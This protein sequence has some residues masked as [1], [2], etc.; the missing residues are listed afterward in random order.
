MIRSDESWLG[1]KDIWTT[2]V[3]SFQPG[4][5]GPGG[6]KDD[7]VLKVGGWGDWYFTLIW[8]GMPSTGHKPQ[9]AAIALYSKD[10]EDASVPLAVD[11]IIH[12]WDFPKGG[13]LWWKDRPG[14]R[15]ITT[16]P[17]PAPKREQWYII[18][19]TLIVKDWLDGKAENFG[20]RLRP[21]H[22]FGSF[23]IFASSDEPDK[24]K[25]PRL[26]FADSYPHSAASAG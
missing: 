8:F 19:I 18:D 16:D 2:S 14:H 24:T 6:G 17:L 15:A 26:I 9:F 20:I 21:S 11:R 22:Q 13:T 4:G 12:R 25:I 23:V 5:G 3:Y 10:N 7:E 1:W